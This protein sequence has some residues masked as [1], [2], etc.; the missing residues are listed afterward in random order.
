AEDGI[1]DFHVTGVQTCALPI[2]Q[3]W[4]F[5]APGLYLNERRLITPLVLTSF[6]LFLCGMAFA[7][8]LVFPVVF[9]FIIST[10]P[11][12]VAV[13]TDIGKYFDFAMT[14]FIAFG[15]AFEVPVA[16]VLLAVTGVVS[17]AWLR[18]ARPYVIVGAF[19]LGAIF[20]PP[21][22]IS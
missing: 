6:L 20:T 11:D 17:I 14:L 12:G 4:A 8:F 18:E 1:R 2:Y 13:M 19:I 16:V 9:S 10:A 15:L 3:A 5:I 22:I 7:Y 21:D